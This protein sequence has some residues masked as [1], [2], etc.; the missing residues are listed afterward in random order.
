MKAPRMIVFTIYAR[1]SSD[2]QN[3]R[4]CQDQIALILQDVSRRF[5]D[6]I[7]CAQYPHFTDEAE[8]GRSVA[9]RLG[10][11]EMIRLSQ[12]QNQFTRYC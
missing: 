6:W 3:P 10:F 8:T 9:H 2:L 11:Q 7:H 12:A 1:Y 4:S 5:P